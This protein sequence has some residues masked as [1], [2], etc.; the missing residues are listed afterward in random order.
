MKTAL[1]LAC[2]LKLFLSMTQ[3]KPCHLARFMC[4]PPNKTRR[5]MDLP[6]PMPAGT[7]S[8]LLVESPQRMT[9]ATLAPRPRGI[10]AHQIKPHQ[11][12]LMK[13]R[14]QAIKR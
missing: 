1:I 13:A 6:S 2:A 4:Q 10:K 12:S 11:K 9:M 8:W 7:H 3:A 14:L 5:G